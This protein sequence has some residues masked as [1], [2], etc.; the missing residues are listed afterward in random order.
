VAGLALAVIDL[1][2]HRLPDVITLP[3][4]P[5]TAVLLAGAAA[6]GDSWWPL[7]RAGLGAAVLFGVYYLVAVAVPGGMGFGDVKL[8][9]LLGMAL[10]W[11]GWAPLVLGAV[12]AFVYGGL[13]SVLLMAARRATRATRV[14]FG[15]FMLAGA[16]TA[17]WLGQAGSAEYLSVLAWPR[18]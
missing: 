15:P 13:G 18:A 14:P 4:Y 1:S 11:A 16:V 17:L 5:L 10:G 7:A 12:L 6:A 3:S 2:V 9:G 8:A